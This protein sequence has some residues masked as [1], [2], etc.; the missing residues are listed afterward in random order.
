MR[1]FVDIKCQNNSNMNPNFLAIA[2]SA[3]YLGLERIEATEFILL[4]MGEM[5]LQD[6]I[7]YTVN[8]GVTKYLARRSEALSRDFFW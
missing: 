7:N 1:D 8:V 2:N 5:S 4:H 3:L 6:F